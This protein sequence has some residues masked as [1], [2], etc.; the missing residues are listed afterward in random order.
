[1]TRRDLLQAG[2]LGLGGLGLSGLLRHE[3]R[4]AAPRSRVRSVILV[5]HYG[6][7]SHIDLWDPK[8]DA[9]AEIRGEFRTIPTT[10]P[11]YRVTE[12]MP[13]LSQWCHK[14]AIVRSMTHTIANHNPGTY[15]A[16]TGHTPE[17]DVVQVG[18][19]PADWPAYGSVL[20]RFSPSSGPVPPFVQ[21]PHVA[22]DQ[23]YRCP[24]QWAGW[25]GKKYDPLLVV[26]DPNSPDYRVDE[27]SLPADL[28]AERL[29]DRHALLAQLDR[30]ARQFDAGPSAGV[31][32][33]QERAFAILTSAATRR[34]FDLSAEPPRLRDR[35]GRSKVGQSYLLARR[36]I[37]AGVRFVTCWNGS[38]PG[39]GWDTHENNFNR[40]KN[41]L[42]PPDDQAFSALLEDLESRG[43]LE[44]TLVI[45]AGEF[46]R[47]PEIATAGPT[48]VGAAG[49][50]HWPQCYSIALAGG[51]TRPGF[52]Y[53][54]SDRIAKY[55][56][57]RP[58]TP[59]D[60]A[61]TLYWALGIDPHAE[62]RDQLGRPLALT[63]G[64]AVT[65]LFG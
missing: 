48:F 57:D 2:V 23:V 53:G 17:R 62:V 54:S 51:G 40:L 22:F 50:D 21:I 43:L 60:F 42:M 31:D 63:T 36:L 6:A 33:F 45:W 39:D 65:E 47:K 11:G 34:A 20:A 16:I 37:E 44:T 5:Q 59:A 49:R 46:G 29:D 32:L 12:V 56:Q 13:R 35:Y 61:A 7:P 19:S 64:A 10:L 55:P 58:M 41:T 4:A 25:L 26:G 30:K 52:L 27:L 14:L 1:M 28:S 3:A 38:N 8:P 24:G 15:L 9:P 18:T